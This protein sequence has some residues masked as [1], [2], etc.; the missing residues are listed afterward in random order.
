MS[1]RIARPVGG[2]DRL[3][4]RYV[5]IDWSAASRPTTGANSIWIADRRASGPVELV[6]H[7]TRRAAHGALDD[8]FDEH[9][10]ERILVGIDVSLGLPAG[11]LARF[12]IEPHW[13]QWWHHLAGSITDGPDNRNNRWEVAAALNRRSGAAAGPFWGHPVSVDVVDLGPRR[14][15]PTGFAEFR[16]CEHRLRDIG[17][18]PFPIWQLAYQGSV[19]SQSLTAIPALERLRHRYRSVR[20]WPFE[21]VIAPGETVTSPRIVI[22]EVWPSLWDVDRSLHRVNDAAQV[23]DTTARL[24]AADVDGSLRRW[25]DLAIPSDRRREVEAEEGWILGAPVVS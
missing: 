8:L 24:D 12:G 15:Q 17:H 11:A 23:L 9:P 2:D 25:F 6:N 10:T 21:P 14:P 22:A 13:E 1:G 7:A 19:G 18:R 3:F 5:V 16:W 20:I 4:D